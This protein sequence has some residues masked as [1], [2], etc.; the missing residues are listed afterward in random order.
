MS[1]GGWLGA[2]IPAVEDRI[3]TNVI[4][5]GGFIPAEARPEVKQMNYVTRVKQP[6]LML[7]GKYDTIFPYE[8]TSKPMFDL[9]GT[10]K[11][12]KEYKLYETDHIP[13]RNEFIKEILAW[14]D[15]YLGPV[16]RS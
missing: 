16:K 15:R 13:P 8:G 14:L 7:N 11:D 1:W 5:A 10:P 12:H 2:V 4:V 3:K 6:T 9:L